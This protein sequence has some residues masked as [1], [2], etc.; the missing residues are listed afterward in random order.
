M[1]ELETAL[2]SMKNLKSADESGIVAEMIKYANEAFKS[3]LA[4]CFNQISL[5]GSFDESCFTYI[6]KIFPKDADL[7][8]LSKWPQIA[9]LYISNEIIRNFFALLFKKH[10]LK[11]KSNLRWNI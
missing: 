2:K 7:N 9:L 5:H 6:V 10:F 3:A 1:E 8:E 4:T 11:E